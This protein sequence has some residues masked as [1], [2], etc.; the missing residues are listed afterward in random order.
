MKIE[1]KITARLNELI[2]QGNNLKISQDDGGG[3]NDESH[4]QRCSGWITAVRNIAQIIMPNEGV[5]Y[6]THIEEIAK[7]KHGYTINQAVGEITELLNNLLLDL[8]YGLLTSLMNQT[9]AEVF[10]DFL[11]H[12]RTYISQKK[13]NEAGVIAGVVFEDSVR[14]ICQN[15]NITQKGVNLDSLISELSKAGI[16]S[17]TKAKRARAAAHV[18]TKATHAQWD[19]YELEDVEATI[20]FADELILKNLDGD[21]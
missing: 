11:D 14:R 21:A 10:D 13:K 1:E 16:I 15:H 5:P 8:E 3:V 4:M 12:A 18:R 2:S 20:T 6:R 17:P 9:R 7:Q 19:E